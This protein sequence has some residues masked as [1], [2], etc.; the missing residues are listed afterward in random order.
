MIGPYG[1]NNRNARGK[2][3]LFLLNSIKFIVLLTYY[4]HESYT[5]WRSFNST[6]S[7]HILEIFICYQPFFCRVKDCK[8]VNIEMRSEHTSISTSFKLTAIKFKV[9]EKIAARIDW[10]LI[11]YHK[12]NNKLFSN[13][14]SNYIDQSNTYS[15]YNKH[16]LESGTNT[17][18]IIN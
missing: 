9:N 6:R 5:T 1:I 7:L 17:A 4:G 13:S 2:D 3:L 10:K 18:T 14:L 15:N 8:V 11:G 16:I 12:L